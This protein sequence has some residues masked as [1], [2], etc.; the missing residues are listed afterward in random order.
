MS[1]EAWLAEGLVEQSW[2]ETVGLFFKGFG[3]MRGRRVSR[4]ARLKEGVVE[5]HS[6]EQSWLSMEGLTK[7][8][9]K[10]VV[11]REGRA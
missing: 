7:Q 10:K 6:F 8:R 1:K 9:G 5:Q 2:S 3:N 4:E 11:K